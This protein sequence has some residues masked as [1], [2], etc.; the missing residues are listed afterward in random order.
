MRL[1]NGKCP[2]YTNYCD[3]R[4]EQPAKTRQ[5]SLPEE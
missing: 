5:A 1:M 2:G 4:L 3:F